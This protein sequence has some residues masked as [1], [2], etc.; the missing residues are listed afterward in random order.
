MRILLLL[1][2]F[3]I[4]TNFSGTWLP[5]RQEMGGKTLP[6]AAYKGQKLIETF[7]SDLPVKGRRTH[8]L[9]QPGRQRLSGSF[10]YA[11][12]PALFSIRF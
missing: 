2:F 12:A 6:P 9:L 5:V 8:H 10:Y 4:Q 3:F 7:Y 11:G 1:P